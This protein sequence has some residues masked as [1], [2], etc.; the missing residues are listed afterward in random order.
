MLEQIELNL[1]VYTVFYYL[2]SLQLLHIQFTVHYWG[3]KNRELKQELEAE[4]VEEYS[5]QFHA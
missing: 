4:S 1:V 2:A 5:L 3:K